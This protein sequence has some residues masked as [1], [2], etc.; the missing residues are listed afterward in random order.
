[1]HDARANPPGGANLRRALVL[2]LAVLASL[3]FVRGGSPKMALSFKNP[4]YSGQK[5]T[6]I[7]V[8]ALNGRAA[9]R[10][11]FEDEM[12]AAITR[13][14]V[15]ATQSYV[16]L[17]RPDA[18]PINMSDVKVVIKDQN[19]DGVVVAGLTKAE[20]KTVNVPGTVYTPLP[21][22][23]TFDDYYGVMYPVVY[24]P[25]YSETLKIAQVETNVYSTTAKPAGEL[26]WT[27]TTNSFDAKSPMKVIRELV[28]LVVQELEKQD[29]IAPNPRRNSVPTSAEE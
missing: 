8:L 11:E 29:V 13:P 1:M 17:P 12:V 20:K 6:N 22:Y 19:F 25:G 4:Q 24:S 3:T 9:N 5:L 2:L 26:V 16:F 18:T 7:L 10:A 14:G 21:Y 28:K 15:Q 27:G 23:G